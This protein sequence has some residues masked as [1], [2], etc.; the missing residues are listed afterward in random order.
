MTGLSV[1]EEIRGKEEGEAVAD[2]GGEEFEGNYGNIT[3]IK[4][5]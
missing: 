5:C 3:Q 1:T 4:T 2:G